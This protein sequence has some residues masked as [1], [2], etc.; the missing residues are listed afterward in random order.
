MLF[1]SYSFFKV[2]SMNS[3]SLNY[4]SIA[5]IFSLL[6]LSIFSNSSNFPAY[7]FSKLRMWNT[8][9]CWIF[10][11]HSI[12]INNIF[13]QLL[14][15]SWNLF[16]LFLCNNKLFFY[17]CNLS[18]KQS[19]L[20]LI[21]ILINLCNF[22]QFLDLSHILFLDGSYFTFKLIQFFSLLSLAIAQLSKMK[23]ILLF[24]AARFQGWAELLLSQYQFL[25]VLIVC[26]RQVKFFEI[27]LYRLVQHLLR[28]KAFV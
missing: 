1:K 26:V 15:N 2:V 3:S 21:I 23:G 6:E 16:V 28:L 19:Y 11:N 8:D 10:V 9:F 20:S 24:S 18:L 27:L 7:S 25:W 13:S 22:M 4:F 5:S 14:I 12:A 17:F